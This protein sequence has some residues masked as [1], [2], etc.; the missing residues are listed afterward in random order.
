[1]FNK[2]FTRKSMDSKCYTLYSFEYNPNLTQLL[3]NLLVDYFKSEL[4][5]KFKYLG[6]YDESYKDSYNYINNFY[7]KI[8]KVKW[9][10]LVNIT[11]DDEDMRSKNRRVSIEFN[12]T[13]PILTTIVISE[14]YKF[15]FEDF[16]KKYFEIFKPVYGFSYLAN[17]NYW[18]TAYA[19]GDWQHI[20]SIPMIDNLSK[21]KMQNWS[22]NCEKIQ[23]GYIREIY[24]ENLLNQIHLDRLINGRSLKEII[25]GDNLGTLNNINHYLFLWKLNDSQLIFAKQICNNSGIYL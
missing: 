13:R 23:Q 3:F 20:N 6:F 5:I 16:I 19:I 10:E 17:I 1:M 7:S 2:F 18:P 24:K 22:K 12:I 15:N 8:T 21:E 4:N 9:N 11:L 25:I 14:D